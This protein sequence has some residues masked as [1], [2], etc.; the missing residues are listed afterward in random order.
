MTD[1][2]RLL[3]RWQ[4]AGV[5]EPRA[6]ERIRLWES[7]QK[8]PAAPRPGRPHKQVQVA[9][10]MGW[11]GIVAL[12]LGGL[13]LGC[14]VILFAAAHWDNLGPAARL[15]LV[16]SMVAVLHLAG[17]VVRDKY[18]NLSTTLHAVGTIATGAA[19]ALVGQ[20]FNIQ[21]HWPAAVLIWAIAAVAGWALLHDEAQQ[22]LTFLL[23]PAWIFSEL[24]LATEHNIGQSV[25]LGRFLLVWAI[26]YL[27]AFLGSRRK[28]VRG[29]LFGV[30]ALA[31]VVA[32]VLMTQGWRSYSAMQTAV[33]PGTR[34]W[35]WTVVAKVPLLLSLIQLRKCLLPVGAAVILSIALP[36]CQHIWIEHSEFGSG[37]KG[38]YT[39]NDPNFAAYALVGAFAVF[40]IGWGVRQASKALVNF[41][42]AGFALAVG[43]FYFSSIFDKVGRSIGL[44][45]LGI[46]FLA[47]GWAL[48]KMRRRLMARM[49]H[50]FAG[51]QEVQ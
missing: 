15:I 51:A 19:I 41:A 45:G 8:H 1:V 4:A 32:M 21:E 3:I 17:A 42:M 48:E 10:V 14:G 46:L 27:T 29:I 33:S 38:S 49:E 5:L 22:T 43:W 26:L 7:E 40:L 39:R 31:S 37:L 23:I 28:F 30:A 2:E 36:W 18:F 47:G 16:M 24:E 9:R 34:F 25:Y 6:V 50:N 13:L 44:I 12:V 35:G 20:I 11:Q